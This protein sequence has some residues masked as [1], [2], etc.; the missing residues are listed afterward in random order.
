MICT[1][2]TPPWH[3]RQDLNLHKLLP[4]GMDGRIQ[5]YIGYSPLVWMIGFKTAWATPL[6]GLITHPLLTLA[7]LVGYECCHVDSTEGPLS[8][9]K[10]S[11]F[12]GSTLTS[13]HHVMSNSSLFPLYHFCITTHAALLYPCIV[14][15]GLHS[16]Q[17]SC[18]PCLSPFHSALWSL[19]VC[20]HSTS[21][22]SLQCRTFE[23]LLFPFYFV[24]LF[25]N[26]NPSMV[27]RVILFFH[28]LTLI[29]YIKWQIGTTLH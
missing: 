24:T 5:T 25:M 23:L 22:A 26:L 17:H 20:D 10:F 3:G 21:S 4:L 1:Q 12:I 14:P 8:Q 9:G 2:A 11:P 13:N 19:Q 6:S 7:L 28:M 18:I 16:V 27:K 29:I 15:C